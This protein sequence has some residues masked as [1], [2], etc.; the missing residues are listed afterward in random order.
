MSKRFVILSGPACVGKGSLQRAVERL[1]PDK[2]KA[3]PVLCTSRPPREREVHG[4]DYYFLPAPFIKSLEPAPD[5]A[6]SRVRSDWQA[7]HLVQVE[8]LLDANDLVFAE[9]FHTFGERLG[10]KARAKNV[11][12]SS[13][14]LVP[15]GPGTPNET[16]VRL[17]K[18]KLDRRNTDAE[19]KKKERSSDA[20]AE[21]ANA[22]YYT[23]T[24]LNT[25]GE[26]D[27]EEW[28]ECGTR[29]NKPGERK[30]H[31]L[32][33]LGPAAKWLVQTFVG[34]LDGTVVS[35]LYRP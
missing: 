7:I 4:R 22:V 27:T 23:H 33:D 6:V 1:Y 3:R 21:I 8:E 12:V 18:S 9:V 35:G 5:F 31:A 14:F 25:A 13:V 17:M 15:A 2:L 28:G 29:D 34:I 11:P 32:D 30:I 19:P 10:A 26:D 24:L 16:I 20:P